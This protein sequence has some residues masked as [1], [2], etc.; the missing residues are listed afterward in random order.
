MFKGSIALGLL[1]SVLLLVETLVTYRYVER[2]L[3]REEAQRE[4]GRRVRSIERAV[5]LG[6]TGASSDVGSV[7]REVARESSNEVAWIRVLGRDG[8]TV[9]ATGGLDKAP[10]YSRNELR[11]L[12]EQH[13]P[14]EWRTDSGPVFAVLG[15][16][17]LR[18][19]D[20]QLPS[21]LDRSQ[22]EPEFIEVAM[23]ANAISVNFGPLRQNLIVGVSAAFALLA[24]V[25][26]IGLRFGDYVRAKQIEKEVELAREVQLS[27]FPVEHSL[28]TQIQFAGRCVPAWQVGGDLYDVFDSGDGETALVLGD[29]SGKGLSAALLMGLVQGVVRA[30]RTTASSLD[31][32]EAAQRLNRF[33]CVKTANERFVTLFWSYFN[34]SAGILRYINAGHWPPLLMRGNAH[35]EEVLRLDTGGPVLGVLPGAVYQQAEVP[36]QAG[37]LLIVCSDGILEASDSQKQEIR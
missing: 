18:S 11:I 25:A 35:L 12:M 26:A 10:K 19:P 21:P 23:Y 22:R 1:L 6:R 5:R 3:V 2:D 13:R 28:T 4:A 17:L 33:L 9:A 15:P 31:H 8:R 16:L 30:S 36:V 29:V 27:L 20:N 7:L 34:A 24:A 14:R 37:D 32:E